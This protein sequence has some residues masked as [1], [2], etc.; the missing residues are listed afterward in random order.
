MNLVPS[1][2][3]DAGGGRIAGFRPEHVRLGTGRGDGLSFTATVEVVEYL[4]DEQLVHM[5]RKDTPLGAKL[6]VEEHVR[7][8]EE[9]TFSIPRDK[10]HLFDPETEERV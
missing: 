8:G 3:V 5:T 1:D 7:P 6:P 4:G 9:L 2:V 10:L